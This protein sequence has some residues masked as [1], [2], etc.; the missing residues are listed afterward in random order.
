[1]ATAG[2]ADRDGWWCAIQPWLRLAPAAAGLGLAFVSFPTIAVESW[3]RIH[4]D[5]VA[6]LAFVAAAGIRWWAALCRAS[7][8]CGLVTTGPY[9]VCRNPM[10]FAN[11]LFGLSF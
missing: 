5:T 7:E 3:V 6:W 2:V 1:M 9:S 10:L 8:P 11:L 4:V